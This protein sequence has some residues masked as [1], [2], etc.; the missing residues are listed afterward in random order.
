MKTIYNSL[1]TLLMWVTN[2]TIYF[3]MTGATKIIIKYGMEK[4][5]YT[6][7]V[8]YMMYLGIGILSYY[9]MRFIIGEFKKLKMK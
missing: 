3:V 4:N 8:E 2:L 7:Y 9:P 5:Q 6:T 1:L